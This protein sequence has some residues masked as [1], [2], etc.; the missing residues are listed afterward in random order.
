MSTNPSVKTVSV[1]WR[2]SQ[3]LLSIPEIAL[4]LFGSTLS[5]Y[6]LLLPDVAYQPWDSL[7]YAYSTETLGIITMRGNHPLGHVIHYLAFAL[8]KIFGYEGRAL[9]IAQIV[10]A[11]AGSLAVAIFF[12]MLAG[13]LKINP[14]IALGCS[15]I[16][17][18]SYGFWFFTNT[19]DIYT[20]SLLCI[21]LTWSF[22]IHEVVLRN[23][24]LPIASGIFAGIS[25]VAHQLNILLIPIG[26]FLIL[27][28]SGKLVTL[29]R[30]AKQL[31][32]FILYA[33]LT[34][35]AGYI[36]LGFIA[37]S[38][39]SLSRIIGWARG[40]FGDPTYGRYLNQEYFHAAIDTASQTIL[41]NTEFTC[42]VPYSILIMA[43]GLI[44][45]RSLEENK[46]SVLF[47]S[48]AQTLVTWVLVFWW[49]PQNMKF[50]ILSLV[51]WI[52]FLALSFQSVE[53]H[54]QDRRLRLHPSL[55]FIP[56]LFPPL[57][58]ILILTANFP[59]ISNQHNPQSDTAL[60]FHRAMDL[61]TQHSEP[62][63]GPLHRR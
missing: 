41:A 42:Y 55:T 28:A 50:W 13:Q 38:S 56:Q 40:Y 48:L 35:I 51:P 31:I 63:L 12:W 20:I 21:L 19:A 49:E 34:F 60:A 14:L 46:R 8:A 58:G 11:F 23:R 16:L 9:L 29:E 25:V 27:L 30:K 22:L 4:V 2:L 17:A 61:W 18:A 26:M 3:N 62:R 24:S 32:A 53:S 45:Y 57:L 52:L 44:F 10:N 33:A 36:F 1:P 54:L 7:D 6:L 43:F 47:V 5:L 15:I 39:Y 59:V 37:T